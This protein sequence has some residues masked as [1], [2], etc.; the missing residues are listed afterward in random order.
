MS[1]IYL[2]L[3]SNLG[4]RFANLRLA[5]ARLQE[6]FTVTAVSP[7][8][9]TEPW[10]DSDQPPFLNACVGAITTASPHVTLQLIKS[11]ETEMGRRPSRR[12]GPRLIDIDILFYD[13][14]ILHDPGL[15]IPHPRIAERVFVLAPLAD[16][17]PD[18]QHPESGQTVQE[19]LDAIGPGG[20]ERMVELPFSTDSHAIATEQAGRATN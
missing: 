3:G 6:H 15:T 20:A 2:S 12:W 8:Y 9:A 19:M 1:L 16:I 4:D 14:V 17:I 11:I 18:F 7:V 10:G 13:R 5:I